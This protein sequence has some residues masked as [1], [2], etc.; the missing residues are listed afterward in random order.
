MAEDPKRH[1]TLAIRIQ[2]HEIYYDALRHLVNQAD[3]VPGREVTWVDVAH[4]M[5]SDVG[6]VRRFFD[7]QLQKMEETVTRLDEQLLALSAQQH[8]FPEPVTSGLRPS[9]VPRVERVARTKK[10]AMIAADKLWLEWYKRTRDMDTADN[11]LSH[12]DSDLNDKVQRVLKARLAD[13]SASV[14]AFGAFT[15]M[16]LL[17]TF[18]EDA[19]YKEGENWL[20]RYL[21]DRLMEANR[22]I[23]AALPS[24]EPREIHPS[25]GEIFYDRSW[26][27]RGYLTYMRLP[28]N[29]PWGKRRDVIV[30]EVDGVGV[31]GVDM[32]NTSKE[33][34]Q[35]L[36]LALR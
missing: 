29:V 33:W 28:V 12:E 27:N 2:D 23:D 24:S 35:T 26:S 32:G 14:H 22:L 9:Q 15:D 20:R 16:Y 30:E 8:V 5:G 11:R 18:V 13:M 3:S 31:P 25:W 21:N 36:V 6:L 17:S 7:P 10:T 19:N 34:T 4:A 1:I